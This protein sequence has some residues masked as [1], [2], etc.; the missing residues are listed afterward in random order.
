MPLSVGKLG[1]HQHNVAW[2]P[3]EAYLRTKW[4]LDP[5]SRSATIHQRYR[6]DSGSQRSDSKGQIVL[7][8]KTPQTPDLQA[9]H[10][11]DVAVY[12]RSPHSVAVPCVRKRLSSLRKNRDF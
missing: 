12:M 2:A 8:K 4:H 11:A 5:C 7:Q 3:A 10:G 6:Q 1:P 9:F